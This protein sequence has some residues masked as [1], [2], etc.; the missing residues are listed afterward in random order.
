MIVG[1]RDEP[2]RL[3]DH[4]E[5]AAALGRWGK[6]DISFRIVDDR[7]HLTIRRKPGEEQGEPTMREILGFLGNP[8]ESR[9]RRRSPRAGKS[10]AL[11]YGDVE[12]RATYP[13]V[14]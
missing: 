14:R 1:R 12:G 13:H 4:R 5:A 2:W 3:R 10:S 6:G 7:D 9:T 11:A 8:G